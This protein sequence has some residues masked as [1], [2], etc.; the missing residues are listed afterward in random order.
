MCPTSSEPEL[1]LSKHGMQFDLA[2]SYTW[3]CTCSYLKTSTIYFY[4]FMPTLHVYNSITCVCIIDIIMH[5]KSIIIL[6][7][8]ILGCVC[9]HALYIRYIRKFKHRLSSLSRRNIHIIHVP[10]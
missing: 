5:N 4:P 6:Y 3:T 9:T 7:F 2:D 8:F 1:A 10:M